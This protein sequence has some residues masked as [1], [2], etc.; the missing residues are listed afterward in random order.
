MRFLK[1][2]TAG[3]K[4]KTLL[5]LGRTLLHKLA[6][7]EFKRLLGDTVI[8]LASKDFNEDFNICKTLSLTCFDLYGEDAKRKIINK[9]DLSK[10]MSL[11]TI[12]SFFSSFSFASLHRVLFLFRHLLL[13]HLEFLFP[14]LLLFSLL[15]LYYLILPIPLL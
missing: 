1:S 10:R 13:L 15:Y 4:R 12:S 11:D 3:K 5:F 6:K 14:L 8:I 9:F 2:S 7:S